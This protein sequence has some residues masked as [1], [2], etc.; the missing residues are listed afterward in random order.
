MKSNQTINFHYRQFFLPIVYT[1]HVLVTWPPQTAFYLCSD[2]PNFPNNLILV[3]LSFLVLKSFLL[4][5]LTKSK[6]HY[7]DS[8][9]TPKVHLKPI[10]YQLENNI[11]CGT[12]DFM[13]STVSTI[14]KYSK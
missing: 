3:Y 1:L 5:I 6:F 10:L 9:H 14:H 4:L 8:H 12:K 7:T 2:W 11:L 13:M